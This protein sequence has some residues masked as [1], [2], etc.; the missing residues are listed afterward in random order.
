MAMQ[1]GWERPLSTEEK[2]KA[3]AMGPEDFLSHY[4]KTGGK[5]A[6]A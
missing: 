3:G 2:Q 1:A 5:L 4:K 6:T